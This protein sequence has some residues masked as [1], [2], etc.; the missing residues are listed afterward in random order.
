LVCNW[1]HFVGQNHFYV[2]MFLYREAVLSRIY[3]SVLFFK[4]DSVWISR[5]LNSVP[6]QLSERRDIS[7][8]CSTLQASSVR[9]TRTFHSDLPLCRE[10]SNCSS[11][12]LFRRLSSTSGRHS[13]FDQLWDFFPKHR[14]GK[15][16]TTVWTMWIHVRTRSFIRQVV[17]SK[18][19][20]P[21]VSLHGS[22]A[23]ASYMEIASI[24]STVRMTVV[25]VQTRQ[26]L[27]W[28]LRA[29]EV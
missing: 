27:I 28:K 2:M 22:D 8:G 25:M 4:E 24:R 20:C 10:T 7:S 3:T 17:H 5:Q 26:A 15:T 1:L 18:S 19:R 29:V 6:L 9:T 23:L 14:Y 11:L 21:D 13:V 16:A 12:H